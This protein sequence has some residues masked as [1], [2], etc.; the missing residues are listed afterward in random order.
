MKT[1]AEDFLKWLDSLGALNRDKLTPALEDTFAEMLTTH[2]RQ[3][4]NIYSPICGDCHGSGVRHYPNTATWRKRP[5]QI[6]GHA[7]TWDVCD[8]CWGSGDPLKPWPSHELLK[9]C[10]TALLIL[11]IGAVNA[12]AVGIDELLG[13]LP[14]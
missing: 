2:A 12:D 8:R 10:R 7:F 6:V 4:R 1:N 3:W 11:R 9:D 5:G 13:R 14:K